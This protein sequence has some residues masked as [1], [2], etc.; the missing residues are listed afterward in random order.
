MPGH[1]RPTETV[2]LAHVVRRAG[3]P[4]APRCPACGKG[5]SP[6][7]RCNRR[8]CPD[9]FI[10]WARDQAQVIYRN[11]EALDDHH[12]L[13][14]I[15]APG[16][17]VLPWASGCDHKGRCSGPRGCKVDKVANDRWMAGDARG[18]RDRLLSLLLDTAK[19]RACRATGERRAESVLTP[20]LQ[21]RG[22]WHAHI[23]LPA[24]RRCWNQ[25]LHL[26][27]RDLAPQ[28][29]FGTISFDPYR[30][31]DHLGNGGAPRYLSK[32]AAYLGK[33]GKDAGV[34]GLSPQAAA[35][36]E[37]LQRYGMRTARVSPS[38]SRRTCATM[39]AHR[40]K[41]WA[42]HR[43][44]GSGDPQLRI[45]CRAALSLYSACRADL[46]MRRELLR[47]LAHT[48]RD[49]GDDEALTAA[50]QA[51]AAAQL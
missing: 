37:A 46:E 44:R 30:G 5:L 48:A 50:L 29:G 17:N 9:Y 51:F 12:D 14:T 13:L 23:A 39:R 19:N 7:G 24:S 15:T 18:K 3:R 47:N 35:M 16:S 22:T 33:L 21:D 11:A 4:R 6:Y 36:R 8:Y 25:A 34:G 27:L 38:L 1:G 26:A 32:L 2:R 49:R 31:S 20:E 10:P 40:L 42:W 28:Y 45:T 41:R 43:L